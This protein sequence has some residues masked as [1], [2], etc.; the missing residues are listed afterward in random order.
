MRGWEQGLVKEGQPS[1]RNCRE[2][3]G[4]RSA[5]RVQDLTFP[6]FEPRSSTSEEDEQG[7]LRDAEP[8]SP[9]V[10]F[11]DG[12]LADPLGSNMC[13]QCWGG[14]GQVRL[15]E[16]SS[17]V[18][19]SCQGP[20]FRERMW[21]QPCCGPFRSN[22]S[23]CPRLRSYLVA[24]GHGPGS[25]CQARVAAGRMRGGEGSGRRVQCPLS[26]HAELPACTPPGF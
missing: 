2:G 24:A 1:H 19:C 18:P 26:W 16:A 4:Q 10:F 14:V 15:E 12:P 9:G 5:D 8:V 3:R 22:S 17:A 20:P 25:R 11:Q 23:N 7:S 13:S 21:C 6:P